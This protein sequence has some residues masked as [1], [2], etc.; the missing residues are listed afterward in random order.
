MSDDFTN[1]SMTGHNRQL[2]KL[3]PHIKNSSGLIITTKVSDFSCCD[4]IEVWNET[5]GIA[6]GMHSKREVH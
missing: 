1:S 3:H 6:N 5:E 4:A 2:Q